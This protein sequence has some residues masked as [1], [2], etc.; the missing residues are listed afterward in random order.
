M[1]NIEY[2]FLLA[3]L[4]LKEREKYT[5]VRLTKVISFCPSCFIRNNLYLLQI[6]GF[7]IIKNKL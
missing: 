7:T 6:K 2:Q 3:T 1:N 5:K 4:Y